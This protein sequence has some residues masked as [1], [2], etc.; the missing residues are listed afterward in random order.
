MPD[1]VELEIFR[2][3]FHSI[4]EEMGA[5]LRRSAFSPNI[6]ERRDY[7]C[8]V[9]DRHAQVVAMGDHMPVHLGSMPMSV[10]AAIERLDLGPGDMA[11]VNDPFAGGTH[12]PDITLVAPVFVDRTADLNLREGHAFSRAVRVRGSSSS[13]LPKARAKRSG[14]R[15]KEASVLSSPGVNLLRKSKATTSGAKAR[16]SEAL[17][18]GTAEA[19][20]F[21][22]ARIRNKLGT[23]SNEAAPDFYVAS[24]AHHADVG[25]AAAGSMGLSREIYQEGLRIPPVLLL[26]AGEVQR[27]ILQLVLANVRTPEEREG[28]LGAQIAACNTGARR[29]AEV[30][31]RYSVPRVHRAMEE[32]QD[33][34]ERMT[35]VLLKGI[36][37][38]EYSAED[39][40]DND[41]IND[42]PV[43]VAVTIRIGRPK[44]GGTAPLVTVDFTGSDPQVEGSINAVEAITYSACFY[45]FRCLL[46]EDVPAAAGIMRPIRAIAP[47]GTVVNARPP[48]AVAGGNVEMS[49]RIVDALFRALAKAMPERIPAASSGTMNNLTI[50]GLF[51]PGHPRSG[52][53]FAYYETIAGGMGARPTQDG[54]S[55][56][57]THMTNSLNTPA[58][59][60]EYA[61]PFRVMRY[62]LRPESGGA[63]KHRGGDGIVRELEL[64]CDADVTLLADRRARGPYGLHGGSDGAAGR[65]LVIRKDGSEFPIPAKGSV[66]LKRGDRVRIESPGGGGF[67]AAKDRENT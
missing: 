41:G 22:K 19:V 54:I 62:S 35:R 23:V 37:P 31:E 26:R 55:G 11:M 2:E 30:C 65:N 25:G 40:L 29:L 4:A 17:L 50:G 58:E 43:K 39:F 53:P 61:Y 66:R 64:L 49:Q 10:R 34:A 48:A 67:G 5:S 13:T 27:D 46:A 21:P 38:G 7:S 9:F 6:R 15:R 16:I 8:A 18:Y 60:L 32:L 44:R 3:I 36:P 28:D 42:R 1:P 45:V 57:H 24:R 47:L 63:G 33:Y 51:P 56:I 12:L 59:A 14:V 52:E 20:P